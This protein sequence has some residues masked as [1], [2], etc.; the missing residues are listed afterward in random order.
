MPL[1]PAT[2]FRPL[3][4][5]G[6]HALMPPLWRAAILPPPDLR[7]ETLDRMAI[8]RTGLTD[9]GDDSFFRSQLRVLLPAIREEARLNPLGHIIA[10]GSLLK[11]MC[12]RLWT[13]DLFRR[14]PEIAR[15]DLV[16]PIVIVGPMRSGTTRIQRLLAC[17]PRFTALRLYEAMCPVP[18]PK[19]LTKRNDPRIAYTARGLRALNWINPGNAAVHPTSALMVDE[20]LGLLEQSISGA[21]IEAQRRVPS[22]ARHCEA[23]NQTPAYAHMRRL[24]QLRTWFTGEDPGRPFILKTP[25]HM[26]D[27]DALLTVFP[28]ARLIFTHRDP[29]SVVGSSASLAWNQMV[30]Q[31][32]EVDPHWIG[33][34][35]LHKTGH[36]MA[37]TERVRAARN[38]P[39]I[40][41]TFA[42]ADRD[43][44]RAIRR[45]Y[46]FLDL[47]LPAATL[48]AMESWLADSER[49]H[50]H[51]SHRYAL[52][53]F[54]LS[55]EQV[56]DVLATHVPRWL[57]DPAGTA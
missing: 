34:E 57:E 6:L 54:G 13:E 28:G 50:P 12:E 53:D 39:A 40:D 22:F 41:I 35:W 11:V 46:A 24:L 20:E 45:I 33:T 7:E 31:S 38:P 27:L 32:D 47:E 26:Q 16:P 37:V 36:R 14:H 3:A 17:D 25:Q 48:A 21:Q 18:W 1:P 29:V 56:L 9:F 55:G 15:I 42:E 8:R 4:I 10:H 23:T 43:W 49:E 30:V 44:R 19:S 5:R 52:A 51:R 2:A